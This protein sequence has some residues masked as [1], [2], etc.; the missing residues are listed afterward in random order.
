MP[1]A[2]QVRSR[3]PTVAPTYQVIEINDLSGGLDL[4][5]EFTPHYNLRWR[6][7]RSLDNPPGVAALSAAVA[8]LRPDVV[9]VHNLHLH[10]SYAALAAASA[11]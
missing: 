1:K 9:H 3:V 7:W 4:R 2:A 10:L 11:A 5:R 6:A 8:E